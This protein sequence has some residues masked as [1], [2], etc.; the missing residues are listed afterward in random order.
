MKQDDKLDDKKR[1]VFEKIPGSGVWWI[2]YFDSQHRRRREKVGSRSAAVKLVEKRRTQ[3]REGIKLPENLRAKPASFSELAERA[4]A[5]SKANKRSY[6]HDEQRMEHLKEEFGNRL[7]EDI[8]R[9]DIRLWLESKSEEWTPA[10][11]NRHLAL[12]KLMYRLGEEDG[13]IKLNPTRLVKQSKEN[14]RVRYLSD[15]EEDR[16]RTVI[17]KSFPG[18]LAEFEIALMTGIRQ[19]EQFTREW[20]DIDLDAGTIRLPH[21]KNGESRFAQLNSRALTA[22]KMLYAQSIGSG[23]VFSN[24]V[25]RWFTDAALEAQVQDFK[26]HD[27]RH[28]FASRLVMAGVDIRTVQELMG[29][30]SITMTMRYAH[31]SPK[32]RT[33]ALEKLCATATRTAT[34]QSEAKKPVA[35]SMQ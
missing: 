24:L 23:R 26:W 8:T 18:R 31:L 4:L 5:Y 27:L 9:G 11:R 33:E 2:Q 35:V 20:N 28:T 29:H 17:V 1:G 21:T 25:P 6:S 19:G 12:M 7:A 22:L 10:T 14:G 32:H 34:E 15:A 13:L 16:L 30:K 3:A